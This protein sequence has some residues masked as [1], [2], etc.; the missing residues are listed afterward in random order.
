MSKY[1]L[2][3]NKSLLSC[4]DYTLLTEPVEVDVWTKF[5]H[6]AHTHPIAALCLFPEKMAELTTQEFFCHRAVVVNFPEGE[7]LNET[8]KKTIAEV[9]AASYCD[10]IDAVFPYQA[11]LNGETKA[12][13][14]TVEWFANT[15][16]RHHKTLK[17]IVETGAFFDKPERLYQ[18]CHSILD[19]PNIAFLKT[20]TGKHAINATP[21]AVFAFI[22]CIK[23]AKLQDEV[24]IKV[25]GGIQEPGVA[26]SYAALVQHHF[27]RH[28]SPDWFRIGASKLLDSL[29]V[30]DSP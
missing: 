24:G 12:A 29:I 22:Q 15:C 14:D 26:M 30:V 25:S 3:D 21:L 11:Y 8:S 5:L 20:S 13:L 23:K 4:L 6:N 2:T 10:E 16:H 7:L 9:I 28:I 1:M 18:A 27:K 17:L 19:I